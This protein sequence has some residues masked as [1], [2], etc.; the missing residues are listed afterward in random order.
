MILRSNPYGGFTT[1]YSSLKNYIGKQRTAIDY[2]LK[3][4]FKGEAGEEERCREAD[5]D[6][7]PS[8]FVTSNG[9]LVFSFLLA[10][11]KKKESDIAENG[12]NKREPDKECT[13]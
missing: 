2:Q 3:K 13:F 7:Y 4:E 11:R 8:Y 5:A 9:T 12:E 10:Q 1:I 6:D